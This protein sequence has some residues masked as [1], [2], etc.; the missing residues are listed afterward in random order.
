MIYDVKSC[1]FPKWLRGVNLVR[2]VFGWVLRNPIDIEIG[3]ERVEKLHGTMFLHN[4][5][6]LSLW[7]IYCHISWMCIVNCDI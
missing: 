7:D 2:K 3:K 6:D 1:T 5:H 4:L